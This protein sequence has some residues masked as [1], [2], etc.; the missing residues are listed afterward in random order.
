MFST[1]DPKIAA[2]GKVLLVGRNGDEEALF[3]FVT[4]FVRGAVLRVDPMR[5]VNAE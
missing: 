1:L 3:R 5:T 2:G 4:L